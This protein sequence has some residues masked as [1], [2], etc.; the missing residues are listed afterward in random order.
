VKNS[1]NVFDANGDGVTDAGELFS[2][3]DLGIKNSTHDVIWLANQ[4][5]ADSNNRSTPLCNRFESRLI[6]A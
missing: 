2:L 4:Q 6:A 5:V 3:N 1:R